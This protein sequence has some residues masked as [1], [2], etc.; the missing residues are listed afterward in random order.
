[1]LCQF[2]PYTK[3]NQL[4][5]DIHPLLFGFLS[6]LGC[7]RVIIRV[8]WAIWQVLIR[9]LTYIQLLIVYICQSQAPNSFYPLPF[10]CNFKW[11]QTKG[12]SKELNKEISGSIGRQVL[13][14]SRELQS[15][16]LVV[17]CLK[18]HKGKSTGLRA[19][20]C[21]YLVLMKLTPPCG[22]VF[23]HPISPSPDPYAGI[24]VKDNHTLSITAG[25]QAWVM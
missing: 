7:N 22:T 14:V 8:P 3:L 5:I 13:S 4:Y 15:R 21:I 20:N 19:K 11:F 2:L 9:Y 12:Q 25:S 24:K 18:I 16:F 6:H 17:R 23:F 10:Q 1:M